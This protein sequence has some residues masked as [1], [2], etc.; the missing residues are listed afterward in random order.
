MPTGQIRLEV[1]HGDR[2]DHSTEQDP[3]RAAASA[4][5][6]PAEPTGPVT[7]DTFQEELARALEKLTEDA[8]CFPARFILHLQSGRDPRR[9]VQAWNEG[10][11]LRI[12][13]TGLFNDPTLADTDRL[14]ALGWHSNSGMWQR[15]FPGAMDSAEEDAAT[16]AH[17]LVSALQMLQVEPAE[18]TYD[19][20][21]TPREGQLH[22]DLP[23]LG[24]ARGDAQ[25]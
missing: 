1:W 13:A 12:E 17:M 16:A 23:R 20:T 2:A 5:L 6:P 8:P 18:L 21:L 10:A 4:D 7:W 14:A 11:D 3:W 22:L 15:R 24:I 9:L 25:T 19:G